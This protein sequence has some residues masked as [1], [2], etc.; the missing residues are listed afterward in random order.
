MRFLSEREVLKMLGV[1]R[2]TLL[3]EERSARF[4]RRTKLSA[5]RV[6]WSEIAIQKWCEARLRGL[7]GEESQN[8]DL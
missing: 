5:R 7:G 6:G 4:P 3:R 1:S 8:N 2:S